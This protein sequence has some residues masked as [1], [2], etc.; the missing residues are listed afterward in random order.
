M[1]KR[2]VVSKRDT[3]DTEDRLKG[4]RT[5]ELV[6]GAELLMSF[7][8]KKRRRSLRSAAARRKATA[9]VASRVRAAEDDL[10]VLEQDLADLQLEAE[11]ARDEV[12]AGAEAALDQ[13]V[14]KEVR[15][16]KNDIDLRGFGLLWVPVTRRL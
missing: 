11:A 9:G 3:H 8:A 10:E 4:E 15:L 6:N 16:E 5:Q 2:G 7:F 1:E 14:E 12:E 13:I